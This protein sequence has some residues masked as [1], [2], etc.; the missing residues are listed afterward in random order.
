[1]INIDYLLTKDHL[2]TNS[3]FYPRLKVT[4]RLNQNNPYPDGTKISAY[5]DCGSEYAKFP[6]LI[7]DFPV[8]GLMPVGQQNP[9]EQ[10]LLKQ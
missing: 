1:M 5:M 7:H 2:K 8:E 4:L 3:D 6:H 9:W 10:L